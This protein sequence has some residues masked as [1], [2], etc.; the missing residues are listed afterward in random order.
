MKKYRVQFIHKHGY[1]GDGDVVAKSPQQAKAIVKKQTA[2]HFGYMKVIGCKVYEYDDM[3]RDCKETCVLDEG[4]G[5]G[6][7]IYPDDPDELGDME[8]YERECLRKEMQTG[9][10]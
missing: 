5:Y 3:D 2:K 9:K 1:Y 4:A 8:Q 10:Y 6:D 7:D